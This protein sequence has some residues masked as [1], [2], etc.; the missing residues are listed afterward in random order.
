MTQRV[1][2]VRV[3]AEAICLKSVRA[4][5]ASAMQ[6]ASEEEVEMV[7]LALGEAC[8]NVV[9]HRAP[10]P[11]RDD[12]DLVM[13]L[14]PDLVRLRIGCFCARSDLA[15][16]HPPQDGAQTGGSGGLGMQ[17][18][19]QIMDRVRFEPDPNT[20]GAMILVLEKRLGKETP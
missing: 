9:Q 3:P 16:I 11:G 12:I 10:I 15:R 20:P 18:I 13:E 4:F 8:S 6:D 1:Y 14:L 5:V 7:I 2:H 19:G 17:F